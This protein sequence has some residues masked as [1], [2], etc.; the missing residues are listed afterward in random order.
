[1]EVRLIV[2]DASGQDMSLAYDTSAFSSL[3]NLSFAPPVP[4]TSL[5][6][7]NNPTPPIADTAAQAVLP[8]D[9]T[10]TTATLLYKYSLPSNNSGLL[11]KGTELGLGETDPTKR[12]VWS[13]GILAS[14]L[15][16]AG[17]VFIDIWA[18]IRNFQLSQSGAMTMYLRDYDGATYTEISNGSVFAVDWQE[19]AGTF[20]ERTIMMADV[21]YTV[22]AGNEME[23]RLIVD[24]IKASKDMWIAYDTVSYP[25]VIKLP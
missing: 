6:L 21:N 11:L 20:V 1:M 14:P 16:I 23:V 10:A 18:A 15:V 3:V 22:P 17:D 24:T 13:T 7:H 12:Q 8:L 4:S 9:A 25:S 5:F 2:D 19:G